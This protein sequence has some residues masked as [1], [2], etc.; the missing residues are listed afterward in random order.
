MTNKGQTSTGSTQPLCHPA[1]W[2][3]SPSISL[4]EIHLMKIHRLVM[5]P[6]RN[7]GL[8]PSLSEWKVIGK[9]STQWRRYVANVDEGK[10]NR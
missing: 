1:I 7:P 5:A 6:F 3:P 10:N 2:H 4:M 9:Q 8:S